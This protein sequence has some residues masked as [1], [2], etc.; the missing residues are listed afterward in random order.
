M[1]SKKIQALIQLFRPEL[2]FAAGVCVVVGE[3]IASRGYPSLLDVALGF[4]CGAFISGSAIVSNDYFDLEV[5]RVNTPG[6]PLP[7][8]TVTPGETIFFT[9]GTLVVGLAAAIGISLPAFGLCLALGLISFLYNWKFKEA[10]LAG[11][12]MVSTCVALT[13]L[14]GGMAVGGIWNKTVW[15]FG[16]MAFFL[17]LGEEIAGDAMDVEGDK[18]RDS[19][20]LAILYGRS[21]ALRISSVLFG[22]V[23]LISFLPAL[24]GWLGS[25]YLIVISLTDLL[26]GV[27]VVGL[28][29]SRTPEEGRKFM[30]RIYLGATFGVLAFIIG[31]ILV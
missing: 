26:I 11:N 17:D 18:K 4:L 16:L 9:I 25:S 22:L 15:A 24:F 13:F 30:R 28:L 1:S 14:L 19:K 8:G 3:V 23:V 10:G 21:F 29:K 12:L 31:K 7:M 20:S 6:R 5:D 2:P 27:S